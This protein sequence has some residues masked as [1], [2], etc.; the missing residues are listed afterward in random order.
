MKTLYTTEVTTKGGRNG[1]VQS[2]DQVL[3]LQLKKPKE[4]G[5][6]G[7]S[8]SNPEQLFAAGYSA[9]FGGAIALVA[10]KLKVA[11][12]D[13]AVTARVGIGPND[14]GGYGLE[15]ELRV[16]IEGTNLATAQQLLETAH[17]VC[18]YSNATR[19][20]VEVKLSLVKPAVPT[21]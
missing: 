8:Y 12:S 20:N 10:D 21:V 9:C 1:H 18:P 19:G 13:I 16:K 5:G 6:E 4:L 3:D 14:K 7:G 11:V 15:V 2:S 17:Q